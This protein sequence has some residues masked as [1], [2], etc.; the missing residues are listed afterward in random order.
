MREGYDGR[1]I[2]CSQRIIVAEQVAEL[3]HNVQIAPRVRK[4]KEVEHIMLRLAFFVSKIAMLSHCGLER[5]L[6]A[7]A[8]VLVAC[9]PT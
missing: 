7:S 1:V 2:S 8:A 5:F 3:I 4:N 9:R 6:R